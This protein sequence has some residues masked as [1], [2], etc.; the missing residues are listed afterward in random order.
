MPKYEITISIDGTIIGTST[1][2]DA[3]YARVSRYAISQRKG[4]IIDKAAV[5]EVPAVLDQDGKVVTPAV[6]AIPAVMRD[7]T[8]SEAINFKA[9]DFFQQ[10][11]LDT[12]AMEKAEAARAASESV[13]PIGA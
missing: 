3:D 13:K 7:P 11:V 8:A 10:I 2:S 12:M 9:N 6:P 4:A 5:P 1:L